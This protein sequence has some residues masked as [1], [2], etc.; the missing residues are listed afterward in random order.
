MKIG[1]PTTVL[2]WCGTVGVIVALFAAIGCHR[3]ALPECVPF[4]QL[5]PPNVPVALPTVADGAKGDALL[6]GT[7]ADSLTGRILHGAVLRLLSIDPQHPDSNFEY[8]T[9]AGQFTMR[10][11]RPGRY[12]Y[13]VLAVN[14][15]PTQGM[16]DLRPGT[17]TLQ[18]RMRPSEVQICSVRLTG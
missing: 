7:V 14:F 2:R 13:R 5:G 11:L 15:H 3:T 10:G 1:D 9:D 12:R 6:V 16:V 18:I 8:S 4:P 17:D